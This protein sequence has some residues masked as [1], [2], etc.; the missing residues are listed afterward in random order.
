MIVA[1]SSTLPFTSKASGV[2]GL[3]PTDRNGRLDDTFFGSWLSQRPQANNFTYGMALKPPRDS[4]NAGVLHLLAA[5]SSAHNGPVSWVSTVQPTPN[6]TSPDLLVRI[7]EWGLSTSGVSTSNT[8]GALGSIDPFHPEIRVPQVAARELCRYPFSS[9]YAVSP[10]VYLFLT[11]FHA[12]RQIPGAVAQLGKVT[13]DWLLDCS[14]SIAFTV[15]LGDYKFKLDQSILVKR[16]S[17][18]TCYSVLVGWADPSIDTFLFGSTF[19][20]NT[21]LYVVQQSPC[22]TAFYPSYSL[23]IRIFVMNR[24]GP[25]SIGF[26][27]LRSGTKLSGGAIGGIVAASVIAVIC[28]G[29]LIWFFQR[30]RMSKSHG[31]EGRTSVFRRPWSWPSVY[32]QT[33]N[34]GRNEI[35]TDALAPDSSVLTSPNPPSGGGGPGGP[36]TFSIERTAANLAVNRTSALSPISPTTTQL[37]AGVRSSISDMFIVEPYDVAP[38]PYLAPPSGGSE[39]VRDGKRRPQQPPADDPPAP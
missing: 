35:E 21:Y 12:V 32:P 22:L 30:R 9:S 10:V 6:T 24:S 26:A 34:S 38:P 4:G 29:A 17:D 14:T 27:N 19:I 20:S 33:P 16:D 28:A 25:H 36:V 15:Q 3:G 23:A 11:C 5:D 8:R 18:R 2:F 31:K 39:T 37:G 1:N 13:E 7:T